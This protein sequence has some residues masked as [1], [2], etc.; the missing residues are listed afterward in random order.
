MRQPTK[1][2]LNLFK[3]NS[4]KHSDNINMATVNSTCWCLFEGLFQQ[5][6]VQLAMC[7][8]L[9]LGVPHSRCHVFYLQDD[10]ISLWKYLLKI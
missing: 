7:S 3:D 1:V 2:E 6:C 10:V 5:E 9:K 8:H 4:G